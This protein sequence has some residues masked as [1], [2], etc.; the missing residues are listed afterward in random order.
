MEII[1]LPEGDAAELGF[2][3]ARLDKI[4]RM[5]DAE[6]AAGEI[7]GAVT[8]IARQGKI[9]HSHVSGKLD[10][11]R[12]E[13][14][15]MDSLFRLYSQTKPMA[16]VVLLA[17]FEDGAF[18]LDEP[19]SKWIPE[20]ANPR[21]FEL[22]PAKDFVRGAMVPTRPA[23]REITIYDLLTMTSGLP[24]LGKTPIAY[25]PLMKPVWEGT[26]ML[27]GDS[28]FNDPALDYDDLVVAIA[29]NPLHADPGEVWH[30][31]SDY[32]VLSLLLT[33]VSGMNLEDLFRQKL[34]GPLGMND[35]G[36]YCGEDN[37]D[38]LVTEYLWDPVGECLNIRDRPE[39][40]EKAG[41]ADRRLMS[42][43]GTFGGLLST[44]RDF[45]RFA[46]MLANGGG[47][48]GVRILGRKTVELM[49]SN[50]IG[51]RCIDLYGPN[52][53]FGFGGFVRKSVE[54]SFIPGSAG[55]YGWAGAAGTWFF[56]DPKEELFGLF[57]TQ[58]FGFMLP[59]AIQ[60][61][62]MTYEALD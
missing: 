61:E 22:P 53:G 21:V 51:E 5:V 54:S 50:H 62:K 11:E 4:G 40:T 16:A 30:Y 6:V 43:N 38:R 42:G 52:Y 46:Q 25:W 48:D 15:S 32:D 9:V 36:F 2:I 14:L 10:V 34:L 29:A 45:A 56:V 1:E 12:P 55:T 58:V 20:F 28:S 18:L 8:L 37:L 23:K 39:T 17:L 49:R 59:T 47:L 35:S 41:R 3:P 44:P 31:G 13:T 24:S 33:R 57:F 26:G 7:P 60:F 19:I 27:P